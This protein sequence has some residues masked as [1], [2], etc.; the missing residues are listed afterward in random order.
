M[1]DLF[2][3]NLVKLNQKGKAT[4]D[5]FLLLKKK[6]IFLKNKKN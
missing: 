1:L 2:N 4:K 6:K 5:I 3:K